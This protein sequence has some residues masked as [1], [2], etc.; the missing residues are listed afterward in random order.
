MWLEV[1]GRKN[2]HPQENRKKEHLRECENPKCRNGFHTWAGGQK[3]QIVV[4]STD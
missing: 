3:L 4:T 1:G 2:D